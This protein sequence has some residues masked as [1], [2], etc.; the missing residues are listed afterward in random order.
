MRLSIKM[1][2]FSPGNSGGLAEHTRYQAAALGAAGSSVHVLCESDFAC[3]AY[4]GC[5]LLPALVPESLTRSDSRP[6]RL[7]LQSLRIITNQWIL[8]Y[9]VVRH[10][11]D[12]VL[13][14]C[15]AEYLSLFWVWPHLLLSKLRLSVYGANFHDPV[16]DYQVGPKWWHKLSVF[17]AYLPL[18]FGIV[19]QKLPVPS[20]IPARVRVAEAPVGI[21]ELASSPVEA[22]VIRRK[23]GVQTGKKVFFTFGFLRNNK[24]I[25]LAIRAIA[26]HPEAFLVVMGSVP[27]GKDR[28][29]AFYTNLVKELKLGERVFFSEEFVPDTEIASYFGAADF[30]LLTYG[31]S[32]V[33]Q[34]GVLNIAAR[35]E[36]PV[37]ASSGPSPMADAVKTYNLGVFVEPDSVDA[38]SA[39]MRNLLEG[40]CDPPHWKAYENYASWDTNARVVLEAAGDFLKPQHHNAN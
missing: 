39:G 38:L 12:V 10:R 24:N 5:K 29:M 28:P 11:P 37:L 34:S 17:L 31:S 14:A 7:L 21:Y 35:A 26:D 9:E 18:K 2:I 15:Y 3:P 20:P 23:W 36:R 13:I 16:R 40:R 33:S 32:F 1:L 30:I 27:S 6:L 19:H 22:E 8:A 25:D 4:P